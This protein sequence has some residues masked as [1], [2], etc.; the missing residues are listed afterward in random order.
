MQTDTYPEHR[1]TDRYIE[2]CTDIETDIAKSWIACSS[3]K[4]CRCFICLRLPGSLDLEEMQIS[5]FQLFHQCVQEEICSIV[6]AFDRVDH[7]EY[8]WRQFET[9]WP[10]G[11]GTLGMQRIRS[12]IV[13][14]SRAS[15]L[16]APSTV[17]WSL[18]CAGLINV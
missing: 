4:L 9:G 12:S 8:T 5:D 10:V 17:S 2:K 3:S 18:G 11:C 15:P 6:K 7:V 16:P 1:H 13:S 14:R